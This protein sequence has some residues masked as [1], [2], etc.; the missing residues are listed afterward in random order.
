[1]MNMAIY[2]AGAMG[3]VLGAYMTRAGY[4]VDLVTRNEEHVKGL[5]E[6]GA[7]IIGKANFI[8]PVKAY[9]PKDMKKSYDIILL[10]TKQTNNQ[11][12]VKQLLPH[13]KDDGVICTM[14]NG[15]PEVSVAEVIG[16]DRTI[17]CAMSWGASFIGQGVCELTSEANPDTLTFSLGKY[18]DNDQVKFDYIVEALSTMGKVT[19]ENNFIGAR[20]AKLLVNAAFSGISVIT[21]A[22]FG[23]IAK[24]KKSRLLALMIMKECIDVAKKSGIKIEP[25]Q[26]KDIVK[27]MDFNSGLKKRISLF[28]I[29]IAMRKH[30]NIRS[31]ML[32]DLARDRPC[33]VEAIN[34]VVSIYGRQNDIKTPFNDRIVEIVR[35]IEKKQLKSEWQNLK[36][37]QDL[38][39][40]MNHW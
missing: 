33:E 37:F 23:E 19:I 16:K 17:G 9:L 2:G 4:A 29:P 21:G 24:Q 14:Q 3:T 20:W 39:S 35:K 34:G 32:R 13:L 12:V 30:R 26:G 11:Q 10:M 28:L 6:K 22:T 36:L 40:S 31:S 18:G 15:I 38:L 25:L 5:Q 8:Q 7:Q 1:M 27:L